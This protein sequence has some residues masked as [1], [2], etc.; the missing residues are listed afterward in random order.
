VLLEHYAGAFPV[1]LAPEQVRIL[2]VAEAHVAYAHDL[3]LRFKAEHIRTTVVDADESLGNRIRRGK[4]EKL[5]YIL[6]VGDDDVA[7]ETAGVNARGNQ[8]ERGVSVDAFVA[9]IR[10]EVATRV[11]DVTVNDAT[12]NN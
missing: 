1:W 4:G 12:S 10:H 6:V 2:P 7:N 3:S 8:V 9:R 11:N 5:P